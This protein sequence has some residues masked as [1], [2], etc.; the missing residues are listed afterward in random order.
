MYFL[1]S[2]LC[3]NTKLHVDQEND[4]DYYDRRSDR[5]FEEDLEME[6]RAEKRIMNAKKVQIVKN[7]FHFLVCTDHCN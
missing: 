6:T 5:R 3:N 7:L 1:V 4:G 2:Y